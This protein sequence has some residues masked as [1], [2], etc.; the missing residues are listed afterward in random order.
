M[1]SQL[2]T[3]HPPLASAIEIDLA[4]QHSPLLRA[5][6]H[7]LRYIEANG[8]IALTPS[9]ALKRYFVEWAAEVFEWPHFTTDDLHAVN[10]V[11]NEQDF[12]PLVMLHDLL[13]A[14]K[15]ARHYKGHLALTNQGRTFA[16]EPDRLWHLLTTQ[17]L[18]RTDHGRYMRRPDQFDGDWR[19]ILGV[20]NLEAHE[21]AS[22]DRIYAAILG[23]SE[24]EAKRDYVL[25]AILYCYVLRPLAWAG[26]L[27]EV[28]T[29]TGFAMQHIYVKTP[30]WRIAFQ[31]PSDKALS[32]ITRH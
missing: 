17:I 5:A 20:I 6:L 32:A 14:T 19:V 2:V 15:L 16:K 7:T 26:L 3:T 4:L 1:E 21:G 13:I 10:K 22:D 27:A 31:L 11:L 29:G 30:L 25:T 18:W 9:K 24:E 8:P 28:R 23:V 12:P